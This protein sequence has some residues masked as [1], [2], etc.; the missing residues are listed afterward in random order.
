MIKILSE[1]HSFSRAPAR[2]V[3][4]KVIDRSRAQFL[5]E[6][7][8]SM[9]Y[10]LI[11]TPL[12]VYIYGLTQTGKSTLLKLIRFVLGEKNCVQIQMSQFNETFER[13]RIEHKLANIVPDESARYITDISFWK[14]A[15]SGDPI[16]A[17]K[18]FQD[19]HEFAPYAKFITGINKLYYT[20]DEDDATWQRKQLVFWNAHQYTEKDPAR[21]DINVGQT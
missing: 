15:V 12:A 21:D 16:N 3:N 4:E 7:F 20:K 9:L 6:F 10:K 17:S 8:G 19:T 13:V 1:D 5:N 18:K 2:N 11:I 14:A